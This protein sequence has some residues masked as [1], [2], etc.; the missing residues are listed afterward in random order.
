M[1]S[2]NQRY[3]EVPYAELPVIPE[4]GLR[5]SWNVFNVAEGL[6]TVSRLTPR[7]V[8]SA[9]QLVRTGEVVNLSLPVTEPDP[10][11][12][13]RKAVEHT[14]F[15]TGRNSK[16]DR[17]DSFYPQGSSQWDGFRHQ[18]AR[19]FGY[20]GGWTDEFAAGDAS[21]GVGLWA[22]HGM[23]GRGVLIDVPGHFE[24]LGRD[25][26]AFSPVTVGPELL[27][28]ILDEEGT[29][30]NGGDIL[31]FRF[32]WIEAYRALPRAEREQLPV[33][34]RDDPSRPDRGRPEFAGL[35]AS[36]EM[37]AFLWDRGVAAVAGDNPTFE[38]AP[39]DPAIGF[40]H[41]RLLPL[42]GMPIGELFDFEKIARVCR[43]EERWEFLFVSVPLNLPGG[44]GSPAN[45]VA[46]L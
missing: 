15:G 16:D 10:P 41:R 4:L 22:E 23:I 25:Y 1:S 20:Y 45:A 9:A 8:A 37:A 30:L 13:Y 2:S 7:R 21:L 36:D 32:G 11:L 12:F 29:E 34:G 31:C 33:V 5:H 19:E 43:V 42:L 6:G 27:S 24:R 44:V 35:S 28:A 3:S 17:L 40:L 14:I 46:V 38:V 26:D 39:G 18:S